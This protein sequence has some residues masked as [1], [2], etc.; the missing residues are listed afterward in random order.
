MFSG[1]VRDN[2]AYARPEASA[3]DVERAARVAQAHEFILNLPEGYDTVLGNRGVTL[4]GGQ[5]Q[6]IAIARAVLA[7]P[8]ILVLDN[9]TGALDTATEADLLEGLCAH[10]KGRTTVLVAYRESSTRLADEVIV[11]GEG[12]ILDRGTHAELVARSASYR[13]LIGV[14]P[15]PDGNG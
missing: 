9:A 15:P 7:A 6:R 13:E 3:D 11:L 12:V 1:S 2:V 4:S 14:D 5:R 8:R 10:L